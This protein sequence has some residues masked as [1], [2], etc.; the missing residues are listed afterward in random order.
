MPCDVHTGQVIEHK[1]KMETEQDCEST[2]DEL[3][4]IWL[5]LHEVI[6]RPIEVLQLPRFAVRLGQVHVLDGMK[7]VEFAG[8]IHE[9]ITNHGFHVAGH[10]KGNVSALEGF[11]DGFS[12]T[13][14]V[15]QKLNHVGNPERESSHGVQVFKRTRGAML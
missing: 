8:G 14:L 5:D 10:V 4:Q 12:E 15:P 1:G 7:Q 6:K 11:F 13:E 9:T 2:V 3:L